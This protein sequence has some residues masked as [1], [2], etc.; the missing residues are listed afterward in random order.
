MNETQNGSTKK[1]MTVAAEEEE[2]KELPKEKKERRGFV[3][4]GKGGD[5][6]VRKRPLF[7]H[8]E[9]NVNNLP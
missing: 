5:A 9:Q 7:P 1:K 6:E 3:E 8:K 2:E 4:P